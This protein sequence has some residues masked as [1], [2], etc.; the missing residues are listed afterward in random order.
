MSE[1]LGNRRAFWVFWL[2]CIA[3][4]VGTVLHL[5]MYLMARNAGYRL[6]DMP[7]DIGMEI[8]MVLIVA[9]VLLTAYGLAPSRTGED[10]DPIGM[11]VT[12]PDGVPLAPAHWRLM[13]ILTVALVVDVMKPASLGLVLPGMREEYG[14]SK[15][16]V[17]WLPFSALSGTFLGS[18]L[19]GI[20]ADLY[21]RRAAILISSI[22]FV[23]T[24][25]CGAM[26]TFWWNVFMCFMM[27]MAAGGMLPV[28][29]ALLTE[30]MPTRSRG[31]A[32]V[33]VGALG[34]AGGYLAANGLSAVLQPAFGW[35][36][37]WFLNL[38]TGLLLILISG[39]IPESAKFLLH[40]GRL[41]EARE[42]LKKFGSVLAPVAAM[43]PEAAAP[44]SQTG[45]VILLSIAA[46]AWSMTNFGILL[47]L[48][49]ELVSKGYSIGASSAFLAQSAV[50]SI[51]TAALAAFLYNRWSTKY[52][53]VAS[54][55]LT[56]V[57]LM[58]IML[59]EHPVAGFPASPLLPVAVVVF[60]S[61]ALLA[62]LLPYTAELFP[63]RIRGR[64]TG[65]VAGCTKFGGIFAQLLGLLGLLVT[66]GQ[67][68]LTVAALLGI[69]CVLVILFGDETRGRDLGHLDADRVT[70]T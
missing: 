38:P 53:L 52:T 23:G 15:A 9:G 65:W 14:V 57:G 2:G 61:N 58:G 8:G 39:W 11:A 10:A 20:L 32:L 17:A 70:K 12:H 29:Y 31:V 3:V 45:K 63:A 1:M 16:V 36:I 51:P 18:I 47:W 37:M 34:A 21:G 41:A 43:A 56:G 46:L 30:T 54:M 59:L 68:A 28:T 13:L 49:A 67:A 40:T 42:V 4:T 22:M 33:V 48:P 55:I 62:V 26:P 69:A 66:L 25:I 19:F 6:A 50:I 35:R 7:M 64:A 60:G 27:G 44:S 5:P 24:S